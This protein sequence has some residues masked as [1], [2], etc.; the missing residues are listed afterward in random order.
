MAKNAANEAAKRKAAKEKKMLVVLALVLTLALGYAY[1]TLTKLHSSAAPTPTIPAATTATSTTSTPTPSSSTPPDVPT[2]ATSTPS[3]S[4]GLVSAVTPPLDQGQLRTFTLLGAKDP[5]FSDGPSS[6]ATGGSGS[7]SSGTTTTTATTTTAAQ[8]PP[9]QNQS[10]NTPKPSTTLTSAVIAVNGARNRVSVNSDFPSAPDPST[11]GIFHLVVATR[12][13]AK[14]SIVGGSYATG[15]PT[16]TLRVG[17]PVT[18][19]NTADGTRY[20]LELF[21]PGTPVQT[22]SSS[23]ITTAAVP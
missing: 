15:A 4:G 6:I 17:R 3:A 14:I 18:L 1:K 9:P 8:A 13:T 5:F 16:M 21:A 23:A 7:G 22:R 12:K 11:N 10:G 19:A 2:G 20:T